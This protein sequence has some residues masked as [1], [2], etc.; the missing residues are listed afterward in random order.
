ML[1]SSSFYFLL[2]LLLFF[3]CLF[4]RCFCLKD[5]KKRFVESKGL[6]INFPDL[7]APH[8]KFWVGHEVANLCQS[9]TTIGQLTLC[10]NSVGICSSNISILSS[11]SCNHSPY[12]LLPCCTLLATAP[13][14]VA[15]PLL[16]AAA[17]SIAGEKTLRR[18]MRLKRI[19]KLQRMMAM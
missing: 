8:K 19:A 6:R 15:F 7:N 10:I 1:I 12:P 3:S 18:T 16:L 4:F 9:I 17:A 11:S 13:L 2:S 14:L 5:S